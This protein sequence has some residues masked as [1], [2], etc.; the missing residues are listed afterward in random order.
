MKK[1]SIILLLILMAII[2]AGCKKKDNNSDPGKEVSI[3]YIDSKTSTLVSEPYKMISEKKEEQIEELLY[4]LKLNPENLLYHSAL[5]DVVTVKEFTFNDDSSLTINFESNYHELSGINEV[6]CRA[7]VVK[8]ITQLPEVEF[9]QFAVNGQP[10]KDSHDNL[11]GIM[12]KEDF[13]DSTGTETKVKLYFSNE[14]GDGLVEYVTNI[15]YTGKGSLEEVV[16]KELM[17]GPSQIGMLSTIPEET[18]LLQV[19]M[20]E[21]VCY[22]DFSSKFMDKIPGLKDEI[23]IYS[24]VNTLIEL[25]YISKVQFQIN[26]EVKPVFGDGMIFDGFFERNLSLIDES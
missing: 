21:G 23:V 25:P 12:R 14:T 18:D 22:V 1:Y 15:T 13:I 8:T 19:E 24:V 26:G 10:L 5:T 3:F 4:M 2:I 17:K 7:A 20:K 9:I 11:V 16:L 6:L